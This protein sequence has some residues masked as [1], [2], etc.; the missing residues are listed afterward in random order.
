MTTSA[1]PKILETEPIGKLLFKFAVPAII[2]TLSV[3]LYNIIDRIFI[4][5]GAGAMAIS[6]LALTF[7]IMTLIQA[8]GTLVGIGASSR[9]S[10]VLGM[11][12]KARA[13]RILGTSVVLTL[14]IWACI[15][16]LSLAFLEPLLRLFG[17][18]EQT[19]PYA[20]TY[21]QII[22]PGS[23]LSNF[24][25]SFGNIIRAAG[26]PKK[27][28][29]IMLV[30]VGCNLVL[31]P[32]F[33]FGFG[34]GISGA[35]WAT[36][37][38]MLVSAWFTMRYFV[39]EKSYIKL[40]WQNLRV[41]RRIVQDIVSIGLSPFLM[42]AAACVVNIILNK[43]LYIYGGDLAIGANGII[44]SYAI[45]FVMFILGL[46][47]AMQPIVGYNFGAQ[48]MQ[49]VREALFL[50]IKVATC[51]STFGFI[52]V[53]A[54]PGVLASFFTQDQTLIGIT[55]TGLRFVFLLFPLIGCQ[56]VTGNY[57]QS[58]GKISLSIFLSLTRQVLFLIPALYICSTL[59]QLSGVWAA[60]CVSDGLSVMVAMS[61]LGWHLKKYFGGA[62]SGGGEASA[63]TGAASGA[64]VSAGE[65][66]KVAAS[67]NKNE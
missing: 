60:I 57:F 23:V 67:V 40:K 13:E 2:T 47:H 25:F 24:T 41:Q 5:Q 42:N 15:T 19:M 12:D 43:R 27:N 11:K 38:S 53:Q 35:A 18:S 34:M 22:I 59:W 44:N 37:I 64:A 14:I 17:G 4:G 58:I 7:P 61:I 29:N 8:F 33:I 30:G 52:C 31:D 9:I 28:M 1:D 32:L 65:A 63:S 10:I 56:I 54:A 26:S 21:L 6:G 3:S 39:S 48:R 36:V 16:V 51:I 66:F 45:L 55:K 50:S 49:R 62:A 20:V 46:C